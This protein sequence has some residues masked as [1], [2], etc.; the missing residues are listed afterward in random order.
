MVILV[1]FS[2]LRRTSL[3][4]GGNI[5]SYQGQ[6]ALP[7][8]ALAP[9]RICE[10]HPGRTSGPTSTGSDVDTDS[11]CLIEVSMLTHI[12]SFRKNRVAGQADELRTNSA[13]QPGSVQSGKK[14]LLPVTAP[15]ERTAAKS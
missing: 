11:R 2:R 3:E 1:I 5:T 12:G 8:L 7:A 6:H 9:P 10:V 15:A 13:I 4:R 14:G